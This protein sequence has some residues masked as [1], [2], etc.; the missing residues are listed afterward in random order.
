VLAACFAP[1]RNQSTASAVAW[2]F[3]VSFRSDR[4]PQCVRAIGDNGT[5]PSASVFRTPHRAPRQTLKRS[6]PGS[7]R[8]DDQEEPTRNLNRKGPEWP[9]RRRGNSGNSDGAPGLKRARTAGAGRR[10]RRGSGWCYW[11]GAESGSEARPLTLRL[12]LAGRLGWARAW[13]KSRQ[14]PVPAR[15]PAAPAQVEPEARAVAP[16]VAAA[17]GRGGGLDGAADIT[18]RRRFRHRNLGSSL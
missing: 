1:C 15:P 12:A 2:S 13:T 16:T 8:S 14:L 10:P 18:L 7:A 9:T 17:S 3:L 11:A 5:P 6:G 4:G